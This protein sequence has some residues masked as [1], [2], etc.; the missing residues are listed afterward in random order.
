[1][2]SI[3]RNCPIISG[4][5][6]ISLAKSSRG[7]VCRTEICLDIQEIL[8]AAGFGSYLASSLKSMLGLSR[9]ERLTHSAG[10]LEAFAKILLPVVSV[11]S[12]LLDFPEL[13]CRKYRPDL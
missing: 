2:V 8:D 10:S 11:E 4:K 12:N 7:L 3:E 6:S 5:R 1:M 9:T 13:F